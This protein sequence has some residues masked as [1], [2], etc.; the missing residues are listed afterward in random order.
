MPRLQIKNN[1]VFAIFSSLLFGSI[2]Y[3]RREQI[4]VCNLESRTTL[5]F[6]VSLIENHLCYGT[7]CAVIHF[8]EKNLEENPISEIGY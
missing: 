4:K 6:I 3:N 7:Q 1:N 8:N 5:T 2:S